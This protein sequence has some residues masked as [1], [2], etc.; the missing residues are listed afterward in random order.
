MDTGHRFLVRD[1]SPAFGSDFDP[2][3]GTGFSPG[4]PGGA[5][6][7]NAQSEEYEDLLKAGVIDP[8]KVVRSALQNAASVAALLLTTEAMVADKPEENG[9]GGLPGGMPGGMPDMGM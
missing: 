2:F 4:G 1:L 6:G 5:Q 7:F 8:T 3:A 9:G